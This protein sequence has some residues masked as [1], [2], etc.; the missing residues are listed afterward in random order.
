LAEHVVPSPASHAVNTA[1]LLANGSA[2]RTS[3]VLAC[4]NCVTDQAPSRAWNV[5]TKS[6]G[7]VEPSGSLTCRE[8]STRYFVH[9]PG[10]FWA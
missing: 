2:V 6:L 8:I 10:H 3:I 9:E 1:P 4:P 5:D 7:S